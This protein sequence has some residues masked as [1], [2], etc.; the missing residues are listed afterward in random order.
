MPTH[1]FEI[2]MQDKLSTIAT[3][4]HAN[5]IARQ[6]G[7]VLLIALLTITILAMLCAT[8]LYITSQDASATVQTTSWEQAMSGAEAAV[9]NAINALN[10][11][12]WSGW[13]TITNASL[14]TAQPSPSGTPNASSM[15]GSG[16][17]NYYTS[18][19][20]LQGEASNTITWWVTVD[21]GSVAPTPSPSP[22]LVNGGQQAYRIRATAVVGAPGPVRVSNNKLDND[23]RKPSLRFDRITSSAVSTPQLTRRIEVVVTPISGGG[24]GKGITMSTGVNMSGGSTVDSFNSND[25][26]RAWALAYRDSSN[27]QVMGIVNNTWS[28]TNLGNQYVYGGLTYSG[29]T[30]PNTSNVASVSTPYNGSISPA[31]TPP[32]G[33]TYTQYTG[34][35]NNPPNSGVFVAGAGGSTAY[36]KINGTLATSGNGSGQYIYI[37]RHDNAGDKIVIWVTD[38]LLEQGSGYIV[39]DPGVQVTFYVGGDIIFQGSSYINGVPNN[40]NPPVAS[41]YAGDMIIYGYGGPSDPD[42]TNQTI[43]FKQSGQT[44]FT[45]V[46]DGP[47]YN[48]T[49]QG[50]SV[51]YTGAIIGNQVTISGGAA[52]HYDESL[53][54]ASSPTGSKYAF[55]RWFEDNS[56][57]SRGMIY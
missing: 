3:K 32:T 37:Q 28:Q 35:N 56:D 10:T 54:S 42:N 17:Y 27:P 12:S 38:Q 40:G 44:T 46:I 55:S 22:G 53:N 18:S 41:N 1:S 45:G 57:P 47:N 9:D 34:N 16:N 4:V 5:W 50:G 24:W 6:K 26:S 51:E 13:Y 2:P 36:Y 19:F 7:S 25:G 43:S 33:V 49:I 39:V 23:L 21:N 30:V 29:T 14:P 20:A 8:S 31:P 52:F 11:N 15:P 48:M